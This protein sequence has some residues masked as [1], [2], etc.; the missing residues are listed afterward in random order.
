MFK[1]VS[2]ALVA[3]AM[4]LA[5]AGCS[6]A[7][8]AEMQA[9]EAAMQ[10]A[11]AAEAEQYAPEAFQAALDTLNSAKALKAEQDGKF[12]LFRRYGKA[13][14]MFVRAQTLSEQAATAAAEEKERVRV[15]VAG[16]LT[17][18]DSVLPQATQLVDK[19]PRGKGNKAEIE[20][21]RGELSSATT[22][23]AD[24]RADFD[25]GQFLVAKTKVEAVSQRL[26]SLINEVNTAFSRTGQR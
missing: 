7:P 25:R 18:A 15:L 14:E 22:A 21:M 16:L 12:S 13:A 1:R 6:K 19:A 20:L 11:V 17:Q 23:L 3:L 9:S 8:E 2:L 5:A 4:L 10:A 26:N 24:A